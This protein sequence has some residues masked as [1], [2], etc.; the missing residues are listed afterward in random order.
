M[1]T[2]SDA[3]HYTP[4]PTMQKK[5][6]EQIADGAKVLEIG[7]GISPFSRATHFLGI[8]N[9]RQ[10]YRQEIPYTTCDLNVMN[11]LPFADNEF[12]FV[13]CR[14]VLEDLSNPFIVCNEMS[15][16]AKAGYIETPSPLVEVCRGV[17][18]KEDKNPAP[19]RGYHH[20]RYFV[21]SEKETLFFATKFPILEHHSFGN[22]DAFRKILTS[23]AFSWNNYF[24]WDGKINYSIKVCWFSVNVDKR[25]SRIR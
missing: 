20:H 17:N 4:N 23:N 1:L 19:W 8:G 12:D 3:R 24:F 7:P 22:E 5:V 13:Y 15:R 2:A 11:K 6:A 18:L 25:P 21:W 10:H 16:V 14:H 9:N